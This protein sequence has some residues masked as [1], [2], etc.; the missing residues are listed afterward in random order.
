LRRIYIKK[1]ERQT[2]AALHS[3]HLG[4]RLPSPPHAGPATHR[5]D[6][7]RQEL[8]RVPGGSLMC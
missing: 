3:H 8:L 1:E 2:E 4:P 5:R 6:L 7:C